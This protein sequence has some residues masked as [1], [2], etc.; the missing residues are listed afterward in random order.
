[1]PVEE[2]IKIASVEDNARIGWDLLRRGEMK[3]LEMVY[4]SMVDEMHRYGM[5]VCSNSA[6][7]KDCIQEIFVDL[8]KYRSKLKQT[9]NVKAYLFKSLGNRIR[10][11]VGQDLGAYPLSGLE[12]YRRMGWVEPIEYEWLREQKKEELNK[13][14]ARAM[15]RLP[16]RQK[17]AVELIFFQELPYEEVSAAM[18][19]HVRSVYTLVWKAI[20]S[21]RKHMSICLTGV[22]SFIG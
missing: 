10:R 22:L 18:N 6:F 16:A 14:L 8:W 2:E 12:S 17:E 7:V 4:N 20:C 13:K 9:E 15:Q 5:G 3:G 11:A 21:L 19:L 1:M